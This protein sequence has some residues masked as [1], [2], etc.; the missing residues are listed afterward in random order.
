MSFIEVRK[1]ATVES[2]SWSASTPAPSPPR[3]IPPHC[4]CWRRPRAVLHAQLL[5]LSAFRLISRGQ[6][7]KKAH[8]LLLPLRSQP[9]RIPLK[10]LT[11]I[12]RLLATPQRAPVPLEA[13]DH[14][15]DHPRRRPP[16]SQGKEKACTQKPP[17]GQLKSDTDI[18]THKE[19]DNLELEV[20]DTSDSDYPNPL[21]TKN[22]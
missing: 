7:K 11:H 5:A 10:L 1:L 13:A 6:T 21:L 16:P 20:E 2:E 22:D 17:T 9:L 8:Q 3:I 4:S 15:I 14:L 18:T 19:F 12:S